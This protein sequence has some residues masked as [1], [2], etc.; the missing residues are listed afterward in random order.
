VTK[1]PGPVCSW[2]VLTS[3]NAMQYNTNSVRIAARLTYGIQ[4]TTAHR[5]S[6]VWLIFA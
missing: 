4:C 5:C 1:L 6:R 2:A 3:V